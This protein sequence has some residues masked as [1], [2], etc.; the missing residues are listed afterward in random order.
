MK[1]AEIKDKLF[2]EAVEAIDSG[3]TQKLEILISTYPRLVKEP[4][5]RPS[6]DYFDHPYLLWFIADNPIRIE[7]LPLN[8]AEITLTIIR[9]LKLHKTDNIQHQLDYAIG[10]VSTG[11]IPRESGAQ[12]EL[13][14]VLIDAG[15]KAGGALI[16]LAHGNTAAAEYHLKRGETLTLPVAVALNKIG[17]AMKLM[18]SETPENKLLALTVASFFAHEQMVTFLLKS[19]V[20]PNGY[21]EIRCGFHSHG[22]PLHQAISGGSLGIVKLLVTADAKLDT[23]D[24]IY[25]GTALGWTEH[26]LESDLDPA[27]KKKFTLIKNY[28]SGQIKVSM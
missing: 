15:G 16:A 8:I 26:R 27:T 20:D 25:G 18:P 12:L 1:N 17:E 28:L 21:P 10:L 19:G 13:L 23:T 4:L 5:D 2:L 7:K 24:K 9:Y 14:D 6:G 3:D 22:T 11:R